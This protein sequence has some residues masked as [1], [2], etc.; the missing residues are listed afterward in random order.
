MTR[1]FPSSWETTR[2]TRCSPASS[3]FFTKGLFLISSN[4]EWTSPPVVASLSSVVAGTSLLD[5]RLLIVT[6][7][8]GTGKSTVAAALALVAARRGKRVLVCEVNAQ[9]RV[10]PLLGAPPS[11]ASIRQAAD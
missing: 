9:E 11:G 6:G 5:R 4:M 10:A 2:P 7:K 8:G 3:A 1:S